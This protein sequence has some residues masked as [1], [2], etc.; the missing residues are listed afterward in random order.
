MSFI[1]QPCVYILASKRNGTLYTGVTSDLIKR[2]AEHRAGTVPG[3]TRRYN[4]KLLMWFEQHGT[5]EEAILREKRIKEWNR[6]WKIQLI[7]SQNP[8]WSDLAIT[9]GFERLPD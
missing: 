3:F 2:V 4:V 1:R 8:H 5:I 6:Q 9:L 7:E